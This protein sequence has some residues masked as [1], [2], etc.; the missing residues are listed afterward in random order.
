MNDDAE[1]AAPRSSPPD[2]TRQLLLHGEIVDCQ[3][4][5][6]GSNYTFA[7][8]LRDPAGD[9]DDLIGMYK[10]RAGEAPL[11]DFPSG[12]LYLREYAA[13]LL[14]NH[15]GWDFVPETVIRDG[16]HGIGT[17]QRYIEPEENSHYFAF[18]EQH[19]DELRR[20]AVFDIAT[21]NA[22]RKAGHTFRGKHDRRIWGIDHGLCF[23]VDPKLRT[24]IWDFCGERIPDDLL[25]GLLTIATDPAIP[26][27]LRSCLDPLE[28]QALR[29]RAARLFDAGVFPQL[30]SRRNIPWGW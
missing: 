27:L 4:V 5:P 3:L 20:M 12:T 11:W 21:N 8:V 18:R 1:R 6:W 2:S 26:E 28:I 25:A 7:V 16:P 30:T 23:N 9:Q 17:I 14:A 13:W 22:D 29:G 19:A 15:L 10:P 24:V